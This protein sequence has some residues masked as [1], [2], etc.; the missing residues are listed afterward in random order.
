MLYYIISFRESVIYLS[1]HSYKPIYI[2]GLEDCLA[3][4]VLCGGNHQ[5]V[6]LIWSGVRLS[7]KVLTYYVGGSMLHSQYHKKTG[8]G[9]ECVNRCEE[10]GGEE[11]EEEAR[12][13]GSGDDMYVY[14]F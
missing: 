2:E 1:T 7:V 11:K 14:F 12:G 10:G 8:R 3:Y 9:T 13:Q 5:D 6:A 4:L